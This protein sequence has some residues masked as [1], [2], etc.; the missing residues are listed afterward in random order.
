MKQFFFII[1][2]L[3]LMQSSQATTVVPGKDP[4]ASEIMIPLQ[5][6][7]ISVSLQDYISL[8]PGQYRE[9][10]GK[11]LNLGEKFR[12]RT[13]Q[14]VFKKMIRK[15]GTVSTDK[16]QQGLFKRWSWHWGGFVLGLSLSFLGPIVALFF[17]DEYKWD[18]FWTAFVT[19]SFVI[20]LV[21]VLLATSMDPAR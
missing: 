7:L 1:L 9:L 5:G 13:S 11:K 12:L 21:V 4:L 8:T 19:A 15:D 6:G 20:S 17:N 3:V 16:V 18:R 10:T 2:L 14:L